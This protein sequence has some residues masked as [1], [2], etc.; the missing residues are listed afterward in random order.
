M[1]ITNNV[2][3]FQKK[4]VA[5]FEDSSKRNGARNAGYP[6]EI[7]WGRDTAPS[8]GKVAWTQ[9]WTASW[10]PACLI[11]EKNKRETG[12]S[13]ALQ[14]LKSG[15]ENIGAGFN[16][17]PTSFV[18]RMLV[19][20]T[21]QLVAIPDHLVKILLGDRIAVF[22]LSQAPGA[23]AGAS[24]QQHPFAQD[25]GLEQF[26]QLIFGGIYLVI[27]HRLGI[28]KEGDVIVLV[29][30]K[31]G[32]PDSIPHDFRILVRNDDA[33]LHGVFNPPS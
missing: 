2:G 17:A 15:F 24:D 6:G 23:Q 28:E 10:R 32:K 11:R 7:A 3:I 5:Y 8:T 22:A 26:L 4:L 1:L 25:K 31:V 19:S 21:E 30:A 13:T 20:E 16:P 9:F 14:V 18:P 33:H 12:G 29:Q 27:F